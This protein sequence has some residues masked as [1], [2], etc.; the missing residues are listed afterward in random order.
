MRFKDKV[1]KK[2]KVDLTLPDEIRSQ[3]EIRAAFSTQSPEEF[4]A[5]LDRLTG[6]VITCLQN[7]SH[8]FSVPLSTEIL[9]DISHELLKRQ[10]RDIISSYNTNMDKIQNAYEHI[11]QAAMKPNSLEQKAAIDNW[12]INLTNNVKKYITDIREKTSDFLSATNKETLG[13]DLFEKL[14]LIKNLTVDDIF[15]LLKGE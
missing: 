5:A 3:Q 8:A 4:K 13:A 7:I 1:L 12:K 2:Y 15:D 6:Y 14:S 9:S 11:I 10:A